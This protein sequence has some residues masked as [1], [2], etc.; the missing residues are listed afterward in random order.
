MKQKILL[1]FC[2]GTIIMT[3]NQKGSLVPMDKESALRSLFEIEPRLTDLAEI[4]LSYIANIDST[5][6]TPETWDKIA[7]EIYKKYDSY[8][9]FVITH[10]TDTMA[11]TASALSFSLQNLGK[12]VV[13][14]GA[15]IPGKKITS[16][17]RANIINAVRLAKMDI[18]GVYVLFGEKIILGARS[19]KISH[20]RL[21]AFSSMNAPACGEIASEILLEEGI[22]KRHKKSL[23]LE[24]GFDPRIIVV[25]L[26]PGLPAQVFINL[27]EGPIHG[28]VLIAYGSGNIPEEY[29]PFLEK[30]YQ[31]QIHVVIRTQCQ[32]GATKMHLYESGRMALQHHVIEAFDMS[33]ESTITKFMWALKRK[34]SYKDIKLL[35]HQNFVGEIQEPKS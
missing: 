33:L 27:L 6:M 29:L 20:I 7:E 5:E 12:P 30:A 16:D 10:G 22:A 9:G 23:S 2:G 31:K 1:L 19:S 24:C 17:G 15:Q 26:T 14:T 32:E 3:E 4:D 28:I 13:L 35:M 34:K 8:D 18:S 21:Q 25:S 11:Y